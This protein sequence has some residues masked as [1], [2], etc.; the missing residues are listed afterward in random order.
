M[1]VLNLDL[2]NERGEDIK[3]TVTF[4]SRTFTFYNTK[5]C[6]LTDDFRN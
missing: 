6:F 4:K 2:E 1:I 3:M 5:D